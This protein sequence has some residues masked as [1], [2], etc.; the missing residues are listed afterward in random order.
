MHGIEVQVPRH[1]VGFF[2]WKPLSL[3]HQRI[4]SQLLGMK[5]FAHK[6]GGTCHK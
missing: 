2:H 1:R 5:M 4:T 6:K 3:P